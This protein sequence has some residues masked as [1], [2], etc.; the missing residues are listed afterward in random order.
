LGLG[1]TRAR[2]NAPN[3][4]GDNLPTVNL[5]SHRGVRSLTIGGGFNCAILDDYSLKCWGDN[6]YAM[7][8]LG[9]LERR[10]DEPDE[11]GD[12]LPS[13]DLGSGRSA[14]RAFATY[15]NT[16]AELDNG[17]VKCW[18]SSMT[19]TLG[20]GPSEMRGDEPSDMGDNLPRVDLGPDAVKA[21]A[22]GFG[23]HYGCALLRDGGVKCWGANSLGQ[24]GVDRSS[25]TG[26]EPGDMGAHLAAVDLGR[27]HTIESIAPGN[28]HSCA[29]LDNG[30]VKCWG[31]NDNGTLGQGDTKRR[32]GR[33]SYMGNNLPVVNLGAARTVKML[34]VG[35]D[36]SCAVLDDGALK[37]W[38]DNSKGQLGLGDN[39]TRGDR[40]GQ[41]GDGLDVINLGAQRTVKSLSLGYRHSCAL[42]DDDSIKCWGWNMYGQLGLGVLDD[43][44]DEATEMGDDLP[45]VALG[46]RRPIAVYAGFANSCALLED[47]S[48]KCWGDNSYGELGLGDTNWR[49]ALASTMGEALPAIDLGTG[50]TAL[51][52]AVGFYRVCALLDNQTVKCWGYGGYG[53]LGYGD[54]ASRGGQP[55]QMGDALPAIDFG[56]GQVAYD[57]ASSW[58]DNC[59]LLAHGTKCWGLNQLGQLGQGDTLDRGGSPNQMGH[60]L[61][62]IDWR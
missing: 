7:L 48:L 15:F 17:A 26:D 57:L 25:N 19:G 13:V 29:L 52:V 38:G 10:G 2:G 18:G 43:R 30:A 9:D 23:Y 21:F 6:R 59:V 40:P 24:L 3:Q 53:A 55:G 61:R 35:A 41:M 8:G 37:C 14:R 45:T 56:A 11:M 46:N 27:G 44:G 12:A 60:R 4:M 49:G 42:L 1:D 50:R 31:A 39:R 36:H 28:Y 5:G 33:P 32:D 51:K 54:N 34:V 20:I 16:C 47:H 58:Y 22:G 62:F